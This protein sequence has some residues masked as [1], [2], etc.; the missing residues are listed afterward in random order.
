VKIRLLV[1]LE[2]TNG[3]WSLLDY[4]APVGVPGPHR[5]Y[6]A[7]TT[8]TFYVVSGKFHFDVNG[9][10]QTLSSGELVRVAPG[11]RHRFAIPKEVPAPFLILF[12]PGGL[13]GYFRE[14]NTLVNNA[15]IYPLAET[16]PLI[17][18]GRRYDSFTE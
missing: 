4:Q 6:H 17:E 8:E 3:A 9:H 18:L 16:T 10:H 13:E 7:R 15:P 5:H 12:S 11:I 1:P 14:L 2:A